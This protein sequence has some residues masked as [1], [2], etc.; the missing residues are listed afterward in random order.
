[1]LAPEYSLR[2]Q[3]QLIP[4]LAVVHNFI[5]TYDPSD[6]PEEEEDAQNSGNIDNSIQDSM[7]VDNTG[8]DFHE[9]IALKMWEDFQENRY[10]RA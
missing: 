10:R 1:M 5:R 8:S 9:E 2:V 3:A 6:L 7:D 4:A